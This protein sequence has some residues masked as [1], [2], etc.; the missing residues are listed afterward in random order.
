[1][2]LICNYQDI[3]INFTELGITLFRYYKNYME[4]Q[5]KLKGKTAV[6]TGASSGMGSMMLHLLMDKA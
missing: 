6:V 1:M 5:M 4:V 3:V 2:R